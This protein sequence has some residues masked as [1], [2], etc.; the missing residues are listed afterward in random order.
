MRPRC[1]RHHDRQSARAEG[2]R[3]VLLQLSILPIG[4]SRRITS[5]FMC[6]ISQRCSESSR[7][8][9]SSVS[10]R[11]FRPRLSV[12]GLNRGAMSSCS[13][14]IPVGPSVR[15]SDRRTGAERAGPSRRHSGRVAGKS[16]TGPGGALVGRHPGLGEVAM[17]ARAVGRVPA[18]GRDRNADRGQAFGHK[19]VRRPDSPWSDAAG[20]RS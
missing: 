3:C 15:G 20:R 2:P 8:N 6:G 9:S 7:H 19:P 16:V 17:K 14:V 10:T 1:R 4:K 18:A 5:C 13:P 12:A 11:R